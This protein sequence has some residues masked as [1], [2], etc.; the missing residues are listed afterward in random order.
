ETT[1]VVKGA[2]ESAIPAI[3]KAYE[4]VGA[5]VASISVSRPTLDDV[6]L[7]F[8]KSRIVEA[9]SGKQARST[10]RSFRKHAR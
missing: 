7:K 10:R 4:S 6:F 3:M 1:I 5:E 2:A 9:E 8:T